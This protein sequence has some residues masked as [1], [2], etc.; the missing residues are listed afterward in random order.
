MQ[1]NEMVISRIVTIQCALKYNQNMF[2][3]VL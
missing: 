2:N 1:Y 3:A